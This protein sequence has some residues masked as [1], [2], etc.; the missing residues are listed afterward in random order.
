MSD[1]VHLYASLLRLARRLGDPAKRAFAR[2]RIREEFRA[3]AREADPARL[4]ALLERARSSLAFLR[5]NTP[6]G[7]HGQAPSPSGSRSFVFDPKSG[8]VVEGS[9]GLR[10]LSLTF[11]HNPIT[12]DQVARHEALMERFRFRGPYWEGRSE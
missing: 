4:D 2:E 6:R 7:A 11:G 1:A 9:G 12:G 8:R 3:N 10:D 5:M